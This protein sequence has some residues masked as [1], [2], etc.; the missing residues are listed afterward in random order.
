ME[1][2]LSFVLSSLTVDHKHRNFKCTLKVQSI[3]KNDT[4][5]E[6]QVKLSDDDEIKIRQIDSSEY[7]YIEDLTMDRI[8]KW[9]P[10][11]IISFTVME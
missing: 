3:D 11:K 4:L 6:C 9:A 2:A 10:G 5:F 7:V 1:E 8:K